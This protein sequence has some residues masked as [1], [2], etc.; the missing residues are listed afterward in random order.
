MRYSAIDLAPGRWP[1]SEAVDQNTL[2]IW[3]TPGIWS[4][5]SPQCGL[6]ILEVLGRERELYEVQ[7]R[8]KKSKWIVGAKCGI[9]IRWNWKRGWHNAKR[10][11]YLRSHDQSCIWNKS[12]TEPKIFWLPTLLSGSVQRS[13]DAGII[14]N[15]EHLY[16][17]SPLQTVFP[18]I[19]RS[20]PHSTSV[21]GSP[22]C[23]TTI[24]IR[25]PV[26]WI[27]FS[28]LFWGRKWF[29]GCCSLDF[30]TSRCVRELSVQESSRESS[31]MSCLGREE[32][33]RQQKW[34]EEEADLQHSF[35]GSLSLP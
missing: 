14:N 16:I 6:L 9:C 13:L 21:A 3:G 2:I 19:I 17:L 34:T 18:F 33:E 27:T 10:L 12:K 26:S 20:D 5:A 15:D 23:V 28:G 32:K 1:Q 31:R 25:K 7:G 29:L 24:Y 35:R 4:G 30:L 8:F 11:Y 22:V